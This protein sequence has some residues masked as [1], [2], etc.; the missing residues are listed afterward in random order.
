MLAILIVLLTA[1]RDLFRRRSYLE[2]EL[3]ALRHQVLV[4]QRQ[5]GQRRVQLRPADRVYWV[6]LSRLWPRWREA[7]FVVKPETVIAWHRRGVRWYWRWKSRSRTAGRPGIRREVIDLIRS[8]DKAN[9]TWGA[10]RIHGELLK[11]GIEVAESTV[12]KYLPRL[13]RRAP[14]QGWR[15]FLHKHLSP[16]IAVDFAVVPTIKGHLLFV[17]IVLSLARRKVLHVNVT[18]HPTAAWTAQQVVEALPWTTNDRYVIRDR[19]GNG[20]TFRERVSGLGLEEVVIAARS[21]WQNGYVERFIGSLRRECLDHVI[22]LDERHLL[23]IVLS[24]V[25]YYNRTRTHLALGKDPP[26]SRPVHVSDGG[27]IVAI[28]EVGGLHHRYERRMA[29]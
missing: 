28:P 26:E 23:R 2:A 4:L 24:Y 12:S 9:P 19:D 10:P 17:F 14:S 1:F 20:V 7:L 6:V 3:L 25:T 16:M 11:L 15:T 13:P 29:A 21:P 22:A 27:E 18:A 5:L 8:M